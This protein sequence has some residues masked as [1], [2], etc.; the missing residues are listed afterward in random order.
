MT[1]RE[2]AR[3]AWEK[4]ERQMQADRIEHEQQ[5]CSEALRDS[6]RAFKDERGNIFFAE[7]AAYNRSQR[8]VELAF[9]GGTTRVARC[10]PGLPAERVWRVLWECPD[11]GQLVNGQIVEDMADLGQALDEGPDVLDNHYCAPRTG[12]RLTE[13]VDVATL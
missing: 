12:R 1:L 8:R 3:V 11:C 9:D 2:A 7:S 10:N 13:Y 6:R 4:R 5:M